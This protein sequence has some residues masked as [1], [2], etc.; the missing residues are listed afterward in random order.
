VRSDLPAGTVTLLF[1]DIEGSTRLLEELGDRY[2]GVLSDHRRVLREAATVVGGVEVDGQGDALFFVFRSVGDAL[3]AAEAGQEG[4]SRL[5]VWVRMGV[6]T[7]EPLLGEEGYVGLDVHRAARI[8]AAGHGGQVVVSE[9]AARL[10]GVAGLRDLGLVR[11]KDLSA[12]QRLYQVGE[13]SFPPLRALRDTNLPVVSSSLVGRRRELG[14]LAVLVEDHRL[15]TLVGGGGIGKTRLALQAAA[16]AS[17]LFADGVWWVPLAAVRDPALVVGSIAS[18]VGSGTDVAAFLEDRSALIVL[19]NAEHVVD[20]AADLAALLVAAPAVRLLVTSREPLRL[21][22]E[23][24]YPVMPMADFEAQA[25]FVERSKAIDPDVPLGH[26]VAEIC[27]RLDNLPL[28][29]ELAAARVSVLPP[30][31]LLNR[32]DKALGLLTGGARDVPERQRTLRATIDW[33]HDLLTPQERRVFRRLSVFRGGFE[34]EAAERVCETDLET[35]SSLVEKSLVRRWGGGR[36]GMLEVVREFAGEQLA[37]ADEQETVCDR[38]LRYFVEKAELLAVPYRE[39]DS[40]EAARLMVELGNLRA[41]VDRAV[42]QQGEAA[43]RLG[44]ALAGFWLSAE[45]YADGRAWLGAAPLEDES[46]PAAHRLAGLLAAATVAFFAASDIDLTDS[47]SERGLQIAR[48]LGDRAKEARLLAARASVSAT[49]R[50]LDDARRLLNETLDIAQEL[51]DVG[52]QRLCLHRLGEVHRDE[53]DFAVAR[54]LLEQSLSLSIELDDGFAPNTEHSLADLELDAG[55]FQAALRQYAKSITPSNRRS[56]T[57]GVAGIAAALT[58]LGDHAS[59]VRLWACIEREER[60]IGFRMLEMERPRYERW[61]QQATA[62]LG[63]DEATRTR[64]EAEA[65]E[66]DDTVAEAHTLVK[67]HAQ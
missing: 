56:E 7:G 20:A 28:A 44:A 50:H 54:D 27:A 6:H 2:A 10:A 15:V 37:E 12:P 51:G 58:G 60:A 41:A 18:A 8:C 14:E 49:R 38:H 17:H 43:L 13:R 36:L 59:A 30:P 52:L 34:L 32:L 22:G 66:W 42:F 3:S 39:S 55:N 48:A 46:L 4:L 62:A 45:L 47:C 16:E 5:G 1:T 21:A 61:I 31:A 29:I 64:S 25:L 23:Q 67:R 26:A 11:L 65:T 19:D 35:L 57:Y 40:A 24:R 33:S 63:A 53:G 9:S